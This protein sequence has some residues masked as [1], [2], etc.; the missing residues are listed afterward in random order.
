MHQLKSHSGKTSFEIQLGCLNQKLCGFGNLSNSF[1]FGSHLVKKLQCWKYLTE[2]EA[3]T[4]TF[5]KIEQFADVINMAITVSTLCSQNADLFPITFRWP[6]LC[7]TK[8]QRSYVWK[9]TDANFY[10]TLSKAFRLNGEANTKIS[11]Q[12][13]TFLT[14]DTHYMPYIKYHES[15]MLKIPRFL[16]YLT[17]FWGYTSIL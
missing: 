7:Y 17:T 11:V 12:V 13:V 5:R 14:L 16:W 3:S 6:V 2:A 4:E 10:L 8:N 1:C 15:E 9:H